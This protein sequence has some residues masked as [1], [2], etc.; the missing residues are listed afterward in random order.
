MSSPATTRDPEIRANAKKSPMG[1]GASAFE[2]AIRQRELEINQLTQRNNFFMIFQGVLFSG[3]I[4]SQGVAAPILTFAACVAGLAVSIFQFRMACGAKYWQIRWEQ[5]AKIM[6]I[7]L[8]EELDKTKDLLYQFFTSDGK[9]LSAK[10]TRRLKAINAKITNV[11]DRLNTEKG[12]INRSIKRDLFGEESVK[13]WMYLR[14]P[15]SWF[16]LQ[17]YSVSR[18]P[19]YVAVLLAIIWFILLLNCLTFKDHPILPRL[20]AIGLTQLKSD[21]PTSNTPSASQPLAQ[22]QEG[23]AVNA[24]LAA[25]TPTRQTPPDETPGA[26]AATYSPQK[27]AI[28]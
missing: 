2:L 13:W 15:T 27:K 17:K 14:H 28:H 8:F 9:Y 11:D 24:N 10:E 19:I 6:E 16:I 22:K 25:G 26:K 5:A 18:T 23:N 20:P 1:N 4:Q 7:Y 21:S 12:F 3:L